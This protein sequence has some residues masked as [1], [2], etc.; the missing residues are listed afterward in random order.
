[1]L[2]RWVIV[3]G[4]VLVAFVVLSLA[5][6]RITPEPVRSAITQPGP[7]VVVGL[8]GAQWADV[9]QQREPGLSALLQIAGTASLT[10]KATTTPTCTA[11]AWLSLSAAEGADASCRQP[12]PRVNG[13]VATVPGWSWRRRANPHA[14]PSPPN[15]ILATSFAGRE[16]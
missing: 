13:G 2:R 7:V 1:M 15:G 16:Q 8:P 10:P 11:D 5:L 9:T 12:D 4:G 3:V 6:T 14:P